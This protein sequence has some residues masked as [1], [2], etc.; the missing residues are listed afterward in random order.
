MSDL[1]RILTNC[2]IV[3]L[4]IGCNST[5]VVREDKTTQFMEERIGI[6]H[7]LNGEYAQAFKPISKGALWG[8]K[9]SQYF[10]AFM[11]LKGQHVK[12][13]T[14]LGMAWLGVAIE[15]GRKDWEAQY[16]EFYSMASPE[17]K[18]RIDEKVQE[19]IGKF[20]LKAQN[21]TCSKVSSTLSAKPR[22]TCHKSARLSPLYELELVE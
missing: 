7:Y 14:V 12:Q 19:Y 16:Y 9:E 15:T 6:K 22:I 18:A 4:L 21:I 20:G 3:L 10:L 13:S 2:A 17:L 5:G 8:Y 1:T 11:F